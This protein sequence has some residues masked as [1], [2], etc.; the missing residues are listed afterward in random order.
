MTRAHIGL[1]RAGGLVLF[2]LLA[3]VPACAP[4][5]QADAGAP[6]T[7]IDTAAS[8]ALSA[9]LQALVDSL[10]ADQEIPGVLLAVVGP[11]FTWQGSAGV[12]DVDEGTPL[13][14]DASVRIASNTKTYTAAAVLRLMEDGRLE[15]D[16]PIARYLPAEVVEILR[17]DGYNSEAI[18]LRHLLT[19]TG[20]LVDHGSTPEY[21]EAILADP[22][23]HWTPADQVRGAVDWGEP[24]GPPG[25][26][27]SYSDTGYVLLGVIV[28]ELT[29]EALGPSVRR[30]VGL[31]RLGLTR[32]WWE[33]DE[34]E[35][36]DGSRAHQYLG[37][38]DTYGWNPSLDSWGGGGLVTSMPDLATFMRALLRGDVFRR[39]STLQ[40]MLTTPVGSESPYRMGFFAPEAGG[41]PVWGH[42]GF[43]GTRA[44][45][46]RD[47]D[48]A[49]AGAVTEQ[50]RGREVFNLVDR[51]LAL[52]AAEV[53][54]GL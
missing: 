32:S 34:P 44:V 37:G 25:R 47:L 35:R 17:S 1:I 16:D 46:A 31:D 49:V 7:A 15:L 45:V 4:A 26:A 42:S 14:P 36:S 23:R 21:L 38:R 40:T 11:G 53:R 5:T 33:I 3:G 50:E 6:S 39:P 24:L 51:A 2:L 19:H 20:G 8:P 52:V 30:L 54:S 9:R 18:T 12:N 43:W 28:T 41:T 29:G 13:A 10:A 48:V 27:Y 22:G